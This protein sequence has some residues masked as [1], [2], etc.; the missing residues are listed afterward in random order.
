MGPGISDYNI[1]L[2]LLSMI[3]F[4]D[5]H[6][7]NK[8]RNRIRNISALRVLNAF[9]RAWPEDVKFIN[10]LF[11]TFLYESVLGSFSL[12]TVWLYNFL[13]EE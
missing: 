1:R 5:G 11:V 9:V 7:I 6:C 10:I 13:Y 2:I 8:F 3:K 4:R 12:I